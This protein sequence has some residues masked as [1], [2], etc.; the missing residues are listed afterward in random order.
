MWL[1]ADIGVRVD[2]STLVPWTGEML[3][4]ARTQITGAIETMEF[5]QAWK[6][7]LP[8]PWVENASLN[9]IQGS[10]VHPSSSTIRY[11]RDGGVAD[12][13][14]ATASST[15]PATRKWHERFKQT[16]K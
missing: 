10:F 9:V 13:A 11:S 2:G 5:M 1:T 12:P 7:S 8:E 4:A 6:D 3:L 16:R 14:S 15:K